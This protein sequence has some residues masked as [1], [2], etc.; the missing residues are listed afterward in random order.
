[1]CNKDAS[2]QRG[3]ALII[4]AV[5]IL[6]VG[7]AGNVVLLSARRDINQSSKNLEYIKAKYLAETAVNWGLAFVKRTKNPFSC[8]THDSTGVGILAN[9]QPSPPMPSGSCNN[10]EAFLWKGKFE[11]FEYPSTTITNGWVEQ[12][13][14]K[15]E[16]AI[17]GTL[18]EK[19]RIK[20]WY[21][22]STTIHIIGEGIYGKTSATVDLVGEI[23]L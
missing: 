10:G 19:Y 3:A 16:Y 17:T 20:I 8:A 22:T 1:M 14:T 2:K 21:P 18:N 5:L 12:K 11:L 6:L 15:P 9:Y 4:V 7:L 13:P 23:K